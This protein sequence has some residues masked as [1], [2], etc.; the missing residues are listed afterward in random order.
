M[1][2]QTSLEQ[3]SKFNPIYWIRRMY[4]WVLSLAQTSYASPAL[5]GL[6]VIEA[7]FF[8]IPP[9]VLLL[10][11]GLSKPK[12]VF[13][14]SSICL[15][16]SVLG[17]LVG[18]YLGGHFWES[19]DSF[20]YQYIP[21]FSQ[22]KFVQV[23]SLYQENAFWALFLAGFTPIPFKIFTVTAGVAKVQIDT[24]IIAATIGRG[25]RFFLVGICVYFFGDKAKDIIENHFE[26]LTIAFSIMIIAGFVLLKYLH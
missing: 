5:F 17:G 20:F 19:Y 2:E 4:L 11:M 22:E 18:Y 7:I 8:P 6:A 16:G 21:G 12:R 14:F 25:M 1:N 15:V 23:Q 24:F 13:L 9:D 10:A 26:K 3:Y